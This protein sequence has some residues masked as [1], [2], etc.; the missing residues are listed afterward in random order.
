MARIDSPP[1]SR[2]KIRCARLC[3]SVRNRAGFE[4]RAGAGTEL[5]FDQTA[6]I[7]QILLIGKHLLKNPALGAKPLRIGR[8]LRAEAGVQAGP[9]E[10]GGSAK[11]SFWREG[12]KSI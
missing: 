1:M 5:P 6:S 9:R 7:A 11:L 3:S 4:T 8:P 12:Q 2:A 10:D